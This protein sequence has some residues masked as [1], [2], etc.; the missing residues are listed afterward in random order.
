MCDHAI[1]V[2]FSAME[3]GC[4]AF[5]FVA[6]LPHASFRV[7]TH[8]AVPDEFAALPAGSVPPPR[9]TGR[10]GFKVSVG[11]LRSHDRTQQ[12]SNIL[13]LRFP[14]KSQQHHEERDPKYFLRKLRRVRPLYGGHRGGSVQSIAQ[15]FKGG[16]RSCNDAVGCVIQ[17]LSASFHSGVGV[18]R[19]ANDWH[20]RCA[21][22]RYLV[23]RYQG[24]VN[25]GRPVGKQLSRASLHAMLAELV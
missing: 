10:N 9:I 20:H 19:N 22:F 4:Q 25:L 5:A 21:P 8:Q 13:R 1:F 15:H 16:K 18:F 7:V 14:S 23:T 24:K 6:Y 11:Q 17:R 12:S 2:A 3:R